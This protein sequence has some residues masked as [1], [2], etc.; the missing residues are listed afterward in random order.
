[1]IKKTRVMLAFAAASV[2]AML[3]IGCGQS[4]TLQ[5][6]AAS[7]LESI[8][9]SEEPSNVRP[10]PGNQI[11][12]LLRS[13]YGRGLIRRLDESYE[14]FSFHPDSEKYFLIWNGPSAWGQVV[15]TDSF[16]G[17]MPSQIHLRRVEI[18]KDR[19]VLGFTV[20]EED[21]WT[22]SIGLKPDLDYEVDFDVDNT[23]NVDFLKFWEV[24]T[25]Q[26]P[27]GDVLKSAPQE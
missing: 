7:E 2:V 18:Q 1:M 9:S 8:L 22:K 14:R 12:E 11:R 19:A 13:S 6:K 15:F 27:G 3:L 5:D 21:N 25:Q 4:K 16:T 10:A 26:S 20:P 23:E 17:G 24:A